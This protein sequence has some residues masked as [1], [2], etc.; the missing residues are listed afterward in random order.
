MKCPRCGYQGGEI[1]PEPPFGTWVRDRHGGTHKHFTHDGLAGWG[2]PGC[3]PLGV[4]ER[5]WEARGPLVVCGPW[6]RG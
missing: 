1:P 2:V 3:L 5:M 4:W 6:G